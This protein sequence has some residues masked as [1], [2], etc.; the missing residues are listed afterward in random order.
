MKPP[1]LDDFLRDK[2]VQVKEV[3]GAPNNTTAVERL[4]KVG[5]IGLTWLVDGMLAELAKK[6]DTRGPGRP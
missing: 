1:G 5:V 6:P 2:G 3:L 4:A